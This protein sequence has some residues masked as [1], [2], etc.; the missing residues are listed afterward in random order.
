MKQI[1]FMILAFLVLFLL[2]SCAAEE[3]IPTEI[4]TEPTIAI[5]E[6]T[7]TEPP[8]TEPPET[9]APTEPAE[10]IIPSLG[11]AAG[12]R[13]ECYYSDEYDDYLNYYV[14]IPENAVLEMPL[15]V[16]LHGDG[17][18]NRPQAL[19]D[20]GL[21]NFAIKIY[22]ED[23]PFIILEPNTRVKSWIDGCIP[24]LLIGLI[25]RVTE[26]YSINVDK[27]IITGHSRGAI[28]VWD[29]ISTYPEYFSA[30][31]PVSSPHGS[32]HIDYIKAAGVPV[33]TFAG[34]IGDTERWYH[35]YLAQNV[36]QI[37]VCG[38][39]GKFT[40]LKGC[41]HSTARPAAYVEETFEWM[42]A[43]ENGIIPE[44]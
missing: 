34:D 36:D 22:G 21:R 16:Y 29:M 17:E 31:V 24:E 12:S 35:K 4:P 5:T 8:V 11:E 32:G 13:Y 23:Y 7:E 6:P 40:V 1:R 26:R 27:I 44:E 20:R 38:G 18:V 25:D 3:I 30:A 33:W 42:L 37:T 39:F 10:P 2:A 43:Q 41:N 15:I 19:P 14:H 28:G 9:T